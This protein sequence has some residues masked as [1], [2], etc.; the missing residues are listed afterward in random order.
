MSLTPDLGNVD[1]VVASE[2]LEAG[3]A[4]QN[5]YV[6]PERTTLIAS[7]HRIY[8]SSEIMH[9]GDGRYDSARVLAAARQL[10]RRAV[11]FDMRTIAHGEDT[12]INAVLFGAIAGA[13]VLPLA[14][15][16]CEDSIRRSGRRAEASLRGFDAGFDLARQSPQQEHAPAPTRKPALVARISAEFPPETYEVLVPA[17]ARLIDYQDEDYAVLYLDR[18]ANVLAVDASPGHRLTNES[19]R[20]LALWMSYEDVIRVADL[21]T[22]ADRFKRVREEVGA[23][24]SGA[25]VVVDYL[26]PGIEELASLLPPGLGSLVLAW[27]TRTNR[28]HRFYCSLKI[29]TS[30]IHGYVLMRLLARL[31]FWRPRTY[32]YIVEQKLIEGWLAALLKAATRDAQLALEVAKCARLI[33][34][35]GATRRRGM[36]NVFAIIEEL[37][38]SPAIGDVREQARAIARAREAALAD[39]EGNTVSRKLGRPGPTDKCVIWLSQST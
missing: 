22:R 38:D 17:V 12:V 36:A 25:V 26:K 35:Y 2:L 1:V 7:T 34:G 39:P 16:S 23:G 3:R 5:G 9:G 37:V 10:A 24:S 14:R 4:M 13:S 8:V 33:K 32:R 11:L 30:S 29:A 15:A 19:G 20:Y 28:L 31:K 21:K 27:A 18:M 6:S